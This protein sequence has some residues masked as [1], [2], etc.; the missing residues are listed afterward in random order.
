MSVQHRPCIDH[1]FPLA[2]IWYARSS[3]AS[4]RSRPRSS[5]ARPPG[6]PIPRRW[7][8]CG[9]VTSTRR[10]ARRRRWRSIV[11]PVDIDG[12]RAPDDRTRVIDLTDGRQGNRH[13]RS[14]PRPVAKSCC[15][16]RLDLPPAEDVP[17]TA[18]RRRRRREPGTGSRGLPVGRGR[19]D[20]RAGHP[21]PVRRDQPLGRRLVHRGSTATGYDP[22]D[23]S[24]EFYPAFPS[25]ARIVAW[26]TPLGPAGGA[27]LVANLAFAGALF[28]LYLLSTLEFSEAVARRTVVLLS[29][30]PASFV[31]LSPFSESLFPSATVATFYLARRGEIGWGVRR[32]RRGRHGNQ[33]RRGSGASA[34]PPSSRPA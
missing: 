16:Q 1:P 24:A 27:L 19:H 8:A 6:R 30:Y 4:V 5:A 21:Q 15:L 32:G 25:A 29:V 28:M 10:V 33:G 2:R 14:L 7:T 26:S 18:R 3:A 22:A 34:G 13:P 17:L 11:D 12:V 20:D 31:F 9:R 23:G